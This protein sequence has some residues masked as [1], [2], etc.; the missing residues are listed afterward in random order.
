MLMIRVT[1]P[2][3]H[4][5]LHIHSLSLSLCSRHLA[6]AGGANTH[7]H[8]QTCTSQHTVS[9]TFSRSL[10]K[11]RIMHRLTHNTRT[12]T[13]HTL[14][15]TPSLTYPH[16]LSLSLWKC[17]Y[18]DSFAQITQ[19]TLFP[20]YFIKSP[21]LSLFMTYFWFGLNM[22]IIGHNGKWTPHPFPSWLLI[23]SLPLYKLR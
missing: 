10:W 6:H 2:V 4:N 22:K 16:F 21:S 9:H 15:H 17:P 11:R 14:S 5:H 20:K 13:L 12:H 7:I 18:C 3:S 23:G 19:H 1:Q 8:T